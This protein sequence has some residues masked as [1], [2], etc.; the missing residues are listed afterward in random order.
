MRRSLLMATFASLIAAATP[1]HAQT[2]EGRAVK[3]PPGAGANLVGVACSQ[4]H[5]LSAITHL[6]QGRR[7]WRDELY[8]MILRGAQVQPQDVEPMVTYLSAHFGPGVPYPGA[9]GPTV[10]LPNGAG[11]ELVQGVCGICHSLDR[12]TAGKR[13]KAQWQAIVAQM[14]Y[15]GAPLAPSQASEVTEYLSANFA[16]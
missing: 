10:N 12:V 6:R 7:A 5:S 13:S 15:L 2:A 4:C 9:P 3:L 16:P 1:L 8:V 11:K 14:I